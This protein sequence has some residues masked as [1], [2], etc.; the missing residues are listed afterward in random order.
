MRDPKHLIY[1]EN[2]LQTTDN[3]LIEQAKSEGILDQMQSLEKDENQ[4]ATRASRQR[5]MEEWL[6]RQEM[7]FTEYEDSITRRFVE[8]I[9]VV[10]ADTIQVKIKDVDVVIDRKL[11]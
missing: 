3:E 8:Q 1:F 7:R 9:T 2:L 10:D 4:Q 5:E 11:C 6:D